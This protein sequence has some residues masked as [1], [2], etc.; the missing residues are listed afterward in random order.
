MASAS[1]YKEI[2]LKRESIFGKTSLGAT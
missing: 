1:T 2:F